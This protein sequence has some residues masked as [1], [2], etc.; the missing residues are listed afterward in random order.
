MRENG[1]K[2]Q[3]IHLFKG[4][5]NEVLNDSHLST[6]RKKDKGI[7]QNLKISRNAD[8]TVVAKYTHHKGEK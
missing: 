8:F 4:I 1:E 5:L 3:G 7:V 2:K 6:E